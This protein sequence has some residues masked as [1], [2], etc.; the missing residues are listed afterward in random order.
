VNS[1][2]RPARCGCGTGCTYEIKL[3]RNARLVNGFDAGV[4]SECRIGHFDGAKT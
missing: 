3:V 1:Y 2:F 4:I